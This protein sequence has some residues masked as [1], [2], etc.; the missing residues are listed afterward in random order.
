MARKE[1][2]I[3]IQDREQELTFKIREMPATKLEAW[4]IRALLLLSGAGAKVPDGADL[5]ATGTFL[6]EKGLSALGNIDYEK[7]SPLLDELLG[8]CSRLVERVEERCTQESV[9]NYIIDVTTLFKLRMEAVKLNLGFLEPE[10]ARLSG[11]PAKPGS[12]AP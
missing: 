12:E 10:A 8:C 3:T 1:T 4:I 5:K 6:A 7:A 2:I 11:S 9:D